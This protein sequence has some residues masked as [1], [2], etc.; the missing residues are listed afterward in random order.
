MSSLVAA[1]VSQAVVSVAVV[2]QA[3]VS[4][5]VV[6]QAVVSVAV[7]SQAVVSAAVVSQAVVSRALEKAWEEITPEMIAAIL[8]NFRK[9]LDAC[10]EAEDGHFKCS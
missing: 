9:R 4:A 5:A 8:K 10:I 1:V 6:S 7:V 3:V 2:S